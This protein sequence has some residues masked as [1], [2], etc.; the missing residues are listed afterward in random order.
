MDDQPI[1]AAHRAFALVG[2]ALH[3]AVG[4]LVLASPLVA[5][6]WGV[7]VLAGVWVVSVI[8][9][10]RTWRVRMFAALL[11]AA[12]AAAFWVVFLT[13]GD[14]VLGWSA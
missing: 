3:A 9:S 2:A 6:P 7:A 10:I 13:F 14:L 5:P 4:L 12:S 1:S 11:A 8:V